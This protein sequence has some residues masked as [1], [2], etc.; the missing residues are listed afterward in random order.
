MDGACDLVLTVPNK[1]LV[2]LHVAVVDFRVK[3][4]F[5]SSN[6]QPNLHTS[7]EDLSTIIPTKQS[8][9]V[10]RSICFIQSLQ[11][12]HNST[13]HYYKHLTLLKS[14][15]MKKPAPLWR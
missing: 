7:Q 12:L 5:L 14:A 3:H 2:A 6:N 10:K 1:N 4:F 9:M 11:H 13:E 15:Q 8:V